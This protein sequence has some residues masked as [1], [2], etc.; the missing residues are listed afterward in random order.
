MASDPNQEWEPSDIAALAAAYHSLEHPSLGARLTDLL[1]T[2]IEIGL[3]KLPQGWQDKV[4]RVSRTALGSALKLALTTMN[5]NK[6]PYPALGRM[7]H[8]AA[9]VLTGAAG[10]AGGTWTLPVELP[11]TTGIMLRA[12]A[13]IARG[14]GEDLAD[15]RTHMACVEVFAFGGRS[16]DDDAS[17]TGYFFVRATLA[18][19]VTKAAEF[20]L[21]HGIVERGT[22]VLLRLLTRVAGRFSVQ[23]SEKAAAQAV[24]IIGALGGAM[25][26]AVF[27]DHFQSMA[28]GHFA[29]RRLERKYGQE[30]VRTKYGRLRSS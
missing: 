8:K 28:R 14:E 1:G 4:Q 20:V 16:K 12:I 3:K 18:R 9:V 11:I 26:N 17:E 24:P 25:I 2:P 21:E 30:D 19:E 22:P 7:L 6:S 5:G 13:D 29:V 10:G 15:P 27:I 23:V